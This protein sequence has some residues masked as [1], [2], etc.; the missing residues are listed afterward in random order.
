V[1][2]ALDECE[3]EGDIRNI[4]RLL[5][6][7]QKLTTLRMRVFLTSR[8]ELPIRLGFRDM[9]VDTHRDVDLRDVPPNTIEH[10]ISVFLNDKFAEIRSDYNRASCGSL[11]SAD[12]PGQ[13]SIQ[14]LTMMT[15]PLFI[16]AAT[17]CRFVGDRWKWNPHRRLA[18]ILEHQGAGQAYQLDQTY[19]P[20]LRQLEVGRTDLEME[21]LGHDFRKIIGSIVLL[22]NPLPTLPLARLLGIP[23]EDVDGSLHFLHSVLNI[24]SDPDTPVRLLH[25]SFREFL[26]DGRKRE[27]QEYW[28]WVDEKKTHCMLATR[29]L[30]LLSAPGCLTDNICQLDSPGMLRTEIDPQI[31]HEHLPPDIRYACRYWVHHFEHSG[32]QIHD[33]DVVDMFLRKHLLHWFEALSLSGNISDSIG[34]IDVLSS[35]V[36]VSY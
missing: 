8:P 30:E 12:W 31:I 13:E 6:Q 33:E 22:A 20:V 17:I 35:L 18:A 29:C 10:D 21:E 5:A 19:L 16:F 28:F 2:D 23:I 11:L 36:D 26:I 34:F 1:V 15:V 9:P 32:E 14:A 3:K 4:L 24:P 25:L 27:K 7:T